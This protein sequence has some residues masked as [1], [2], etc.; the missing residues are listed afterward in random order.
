MSNSKKASQSRSG[1]TSAGKLSEDQ[2]KANFSDMHPPLTASQANIEA[3]RCYFC[4]DAP[5]TTACPTGIDIP[6]FIKRIQTGNTKGSARKILEQNIM[7]GMC[8]RVCPTEV[9]CEEACVRNTHESKPV[10][11]GLLQRYATDEVIK[12]KCRYSSASRRRAKKWP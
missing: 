1:A 8:A 12:K 6:E 7:G 10:A 11:I 2:I 9:L 3:G 5:C 4:Y